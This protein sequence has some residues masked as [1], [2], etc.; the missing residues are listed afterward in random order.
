MGTARVRSGRGNDMGM[1][2]SCTATSSLGGV[3]QRHCGNLGN[4]RLRRR[5]NTCKRLEA[6]WLRDYEDEE[7][8]DTAVMLADGGYYKR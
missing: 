5:Q 6:K 2:R 8:D 3:R 1:A 7:D 4:A